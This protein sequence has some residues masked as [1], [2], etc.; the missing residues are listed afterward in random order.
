MKIEYIGEYVSLFGYVLVCDADES[1]H[2]TFTIPHHH[3]HEGTNIG[4]DQSTV[5][6]ILKSKYFRI[7][8]PF[9]L[10][11]SRSS[12]FPRVHATQIIQ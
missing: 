4:R 6:I 1:F 12:Q 5:K 11:N 3:R 8:F 10:N 2:N 7:F 9:M